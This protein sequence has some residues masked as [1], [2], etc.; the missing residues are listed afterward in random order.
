MRFFFFSFGGELGFGGKKGLFERRRE[1]W[2]GLPRTESP[3][4]LNQS[5]P[6]ME[7]DTPPRDYLRNGPRRRRLA[8]LPPQ[9]AVAALGHR[10]TSLERLPWH[11]QEHKLTCRTPCYL[12]APIQASEK[13]WESAPG[14]LGPGDRNTPC[15]LSSE[16]VIK[17]WDH[18]IPVMGSPHDC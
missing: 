7:S 9:R 18:G 2:K 3:P 13:V 14:S 12:W 16:W 5:S 4:I 17:E 8:S 11:P 6:K 15:S 10:H 1:Q